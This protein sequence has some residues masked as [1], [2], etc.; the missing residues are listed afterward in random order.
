M[1]TFTS[2]LWIVEV[3]PAVSISKPESRSAFAWI[4]ERVGG[5]VVWLIGGITSRKS[6][7]SATA[8]CDCKLKKAG[9][10]DTMILKLFSRR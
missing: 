8:F 2:S 4:G 3:R 7:M 10:L 6:H 9:L 5:R 1:L